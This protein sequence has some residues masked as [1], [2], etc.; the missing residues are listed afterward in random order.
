MERLSLAV[1]NWL[2]DRPTMKEN[3]HSPGKLLSLFCGEVSELCE[4]FGNKTREELSTCI[5]AREELADIGLYFM[6]ILNWL[7]L[8]MEE[9]CME[10]LA[11]NMLRYE[12]HRFQSGD[13]NESMTWA[14]ERNKRE[15]T[16]EKFY[17]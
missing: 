10:K 12:A 14:R 16:K 1:D 15:R 8:N 3:N 6:S 7:G 11:L 9:I 4:A 5:D 13:F 2:K 17:Q